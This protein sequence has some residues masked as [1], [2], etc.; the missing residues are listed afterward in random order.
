MSEKSSNLTSWEPSPVKSSYR[1][2][3]IA[4]SPS[5]QSAVSESVA[6]WQAYS[7]LCFSGRVLTANSLCEAVEKTMMR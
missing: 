1:N 3:E 7:N 6:D 5:L 2:V 4:E